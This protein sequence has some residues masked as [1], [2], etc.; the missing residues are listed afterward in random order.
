LPK[1]IKMR[2]LLFLT[3]FIHFLPFSQAQHIWKGYIGVQ[4]GESFHYELH[5]KDSAGYL[6]GFAYTF[7]N[8]KQ[9]V[10]A[11]FS[12]FIDRKNQ[13]VSFRETEL[14]YNHGFESIATICLI[15][16]TLKFTKEENHLV[17]SGAIASSD[18]TQVSCSSGSVTI[19]GM[20]DVK[21]VLSMPE[22]NWNPPPVP[23]VAK[24]TPQK[25]LKV[26]YD[27]AAKP[28][29]NNDSAMTM[30]KIT[31]GLA[32]QYFWSTDSLVLELWDGGKEDGD[33]IS[34]WIND[35]KLLDNYKINKEIR[36]LAIKLNERKS[37]II[38]IKAESEG[39][40]PPNTA[41]IILR[42][43]NK[44]YRLLAHNKYG[45]TAIVELIRNKS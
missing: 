26:V 36:R 40:E 30:V 7:K 17:F 42:D 9:D 37:T 31:Q 45:K 28:V 1:L 18:I 13:T 10:K 15:S 33:R 2:V 23:V 38:K 19:T 35:V 8:P 5:F 3:F 14:L 4:G 22:E 6:N 24:E 12:G 29:E 16:A 41:D 21:Q 32:K 25:I 11:A 27:T 44:M 20:D 43:G 39:N 34:L